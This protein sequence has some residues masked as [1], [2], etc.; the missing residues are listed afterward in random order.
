MWPFSLTIWW[1]LQLH[2][3]QHQPTSQCMQ[4]RTT[5]SHYSQI[6]LWEWLKNSCFCL[7]VTIAGR[8]SGPSEGHW[9]AMAVRKCTATPRYDTSLRRLWSHR[10]TDHTWSLNKS[11][12]SR[13]T[14]DKWLK[15]F[16]YELW[17]IRFLTWL[18]CYNRYSLITW[19]IDWPSKRL[20]NWCLP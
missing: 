19:R 14:R 13:S 1:G 16:Q 8:I 7:L 5:K 20:F 9:A 11:A 2:C 3:L 12:S 4:S 10:Q 15:P 18:E 6:P 17:N